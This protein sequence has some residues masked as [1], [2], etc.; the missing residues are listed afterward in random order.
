MAVHIQDVPDKAIVVTVFTI[1]GSIRNCP[2]V[3][4]QKMRR[5]PMTGHSSIS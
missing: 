2:V 3:Y 5:K 4:F 1:I